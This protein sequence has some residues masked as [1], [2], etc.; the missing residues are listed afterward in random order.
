MHRENHDKCDLVPAATFPGPHV[1]DAQFALVYSELRRIAASALA[2]ERAGH[3]LAPT[4][5]VH[6]AYLKLMRQ[7]TVG[8]NSETQFLGVAAR[9]M[10]QILTD[11]ARMKK[12]AKRD[13]ARQPDSM[14]SVMVAWE[15]QALDLVALDEALTEL[16]AIDDRKVRVIELRF[17]GGLTAQQTAEMLNTPL[18]SINRDWAAARAW[19]FARLT[20]P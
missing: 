10:R 20:H 4:A 19:L 15:D 11:Y 3:T 13:R 17:F 7:R 9:A 5:L 12:T 2:A 18:R 14:S 1:V 6:E 8:W 16:A